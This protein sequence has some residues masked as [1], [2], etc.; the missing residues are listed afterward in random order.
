MSRAQ[1][2]V[3]AQVAGGRRGAIVF[4]RDTRLVVRALLAMLWTWAGIAFDE[5][6]LEFWR[7][8][9]ESGIDVSVL[10]LIALGLA[11]FGYEGY[12]FLRS[13]PRRVEIEGSRLLLRY[14][15][16][17]EGAIELD[18]IEPP[19]DITPGDRT[20]P[21]CQLRYPS[22]H[23][24]V[25]DGPTREVICRPCAEGLDLE[26]AETA[27]SAGRPPRREASGLDKLE[28]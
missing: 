14:S 7:R 23:W 25:V 5:L 24:F 18:D 11:G 16:H 28:A 2:P 3:A 19:V 26:R 21:R 1:S 10:P 13:T 8:S 15:K 20:C 9:F 12:Q 17:R 4:K 27:A 6:D 22:H